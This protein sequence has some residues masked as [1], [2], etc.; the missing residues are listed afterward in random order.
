MNLFT[1]I[2]Q[3]FVEKVILPLY[4]KTGIATMFL[5]ENLKKSLNS[6][7]RKMQTFKEYLEANAQ[8]L[9]PGQGVFDPKSAT[10][11]IGSPQTDLTNKS[12]M[13]QPTPIPANNQIRLANFQK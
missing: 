5:S 10:G 4:Q 12:T 7:R 11:D 8:L 2:T 6:L 9:R 3:S 13:S 1:A